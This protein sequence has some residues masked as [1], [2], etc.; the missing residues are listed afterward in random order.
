VP[1]QGGKGDRGPP[2]IRAGTLRAGP[3][4][5][6]LLDAALLP[7]LP[8]RGVAAGEREVGGGLGFALEVGEGGGGA[9]IGAAEALRPVR[10]LWPLGVGDPFPADGA[11]GFGF[12]I[13]RRQQ[14][15]L[16]LVCEE[17]GEKSCA[18]RQ[19]AAGSAPDLRGQGRE[20]RSQRCVGPVPTSPPVSP[21][22]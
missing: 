17:K 13:C 11:P 16:T 6:R 5:H 4:A 2:T 21:P 12:D 1:L 9:G 8:Q 18:E 19:R 10:R 7:G 14:R 15:G 22:L 3:L 20:D